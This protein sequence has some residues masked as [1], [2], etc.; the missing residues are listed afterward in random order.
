MIMTRYQ[1][2]SKELEELKGPDFDKVKELE[3]ELEEAY[4]NMKILES[5]I[6]T[7]GKAATDLKEASLN[8]MKEFQKQEEK[9]KEFSKEN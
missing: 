9:L 6:Q 3:N 1:K 2:Q 7:T 5:D 4:E 8:L